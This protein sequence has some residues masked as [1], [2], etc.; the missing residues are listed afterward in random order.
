MRV[1]LIN[2]PRHSEIVSDNPPFIDEE[3]GSNPPLGILYIAAY[4]KRYSNHQIFALDAQVEKLDYAEKFR[5]RIK[6]INPDVVGITVMTFTL[7]DVIKTIKIVREAEKELY[8]KIV[9]VL[10]GPHAYL[11]PEETISLNGVDFVIKGEGEVPFYR[12]LNA[13]EEKEE[14]SKVPGLTYWQNSKIIDNQVSDL[15]DNLDELP[16]P[17]RTILPIEKYNS[18]LGRDH[19]VTTMFTSRG[20]PFK[21]AFCDRPH[22]GKKFRARSAHNVVD[23]IE[24]CLRYGIQEILIYDDTFTINRQRAVDICDEIIERGLDFVWDIRA[25]VDTVDEEILKKLKKAG[26]IRIHFGVEA[27]TDKILKVLNKGINLKQ[28]E[29]AFKIANKLGIE[30]LAYF[31]IG[32]P[33]ETKKD[34][35]Q[36]IKFAKKIKPNYTHITILTPFPATKIYF[37]ALKEKVIKNDYWCEFAK[38]PENGVITQYWDKE[39]S[40]EEL[41]YLLDKFYKDFYGRPLYIVKQILKIRSYNDLSKRILTGLKILGLK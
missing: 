32:S 19:I 22:L 5:M 38:N 12:L 25:R 8:K 41:F 14:F 33:T 40:K 37:Q 2:P 1:L 3:R 35:L 24:E 13:L 27:G 21:C 20:C 34:I 26:C 7:I 16:F 29:Y 4:L 30:T 39:L 10:G 18:I 17:D 31:M 36:T 9:V 23:E 28:V 11:Y 6:E 15:I